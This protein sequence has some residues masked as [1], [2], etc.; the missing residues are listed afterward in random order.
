[1]ISKASEHGRPIAR[2]MLEDAK[3]IQVFDDMA[4]FDKQWQ[5]Q[6]LAERSAEILTSIER[7]KVRMTFL[8]QISCFACHF[9]CKAGHRIS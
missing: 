4:L 1:M 8:Q 9:K 7:E 6:M 3:G 2:Q 5:A